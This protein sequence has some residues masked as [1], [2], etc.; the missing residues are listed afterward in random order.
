MARMKYTWRSLLA[1]VIFGL[2]SA[3]AWAE[4]STGR[5]V[6]GNLPKDSLALM[7]VLAFVA[8]VL[9]FISPCTV[10][11]LPAYFS[12][13]VSADRKRVAL[14]TVAFFLGLAVVFSL[15]G[16][17]ATLIGSFLRQ[18]LGAMATLGGLVIIAFGLLAILGKG[19]GGLHIEQQPSATL[20]GSFL[21]GATFALGWTGCIGPILGSFLIMAASTATVYQGM[22]FMLIYALGLGLPLILISTFLGRTDR[23]SRAW[24]IL[25]GRSFVLNL[26]QRGL[27]LHTSSTASGMILL[28]LG[29]LM[30]SGNLTMFNR[31]LPP[32]VQVW[33]RGI[34]EW[35]IQLFGSKTV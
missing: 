24:R 32:D 10:P 2:A 30:I 33:F 14:M 20:G 23:N 35:F 3:P 13:T 5:T 34:E 22:L 28:A 31:Y 4:P 17:S 19:F 1:L 27:V 25:H 6:Q 29:L 8:G 9:S 11:I 16:G 7:G 26:G 21:F 12:F 15:I 18:H